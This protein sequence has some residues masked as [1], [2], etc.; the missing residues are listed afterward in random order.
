AGQT[1]LV[2]IAEW[3]ADTARDQVAPLGVGTPHATTLG[4]VLQ[5]LD[6]QALDDLIGAW[7]QAA[8]CPT[9]I[10]VDGKEVRGAKKRRRRH[11]APGV[12]GHPRH[13]SGVM[14]RRS[15]PEIQ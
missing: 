13:R 12:C 2:E 7:S 6:A 11:S 10:A 1:T 14:A 3:A 15:G 5:R 4:R 9:A 8:R